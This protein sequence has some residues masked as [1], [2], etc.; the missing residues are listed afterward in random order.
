MSKSN[1]SVNILPDICEYAISKK[2]LYDPKSLKYKEVRFECIW[3]GGTTPKPKYKLSLNR[4]KGTFKCWICKQ[5]GGTIDFIMA[6]ENKSKD[7]VIQELREKAGLGKGKPK[8]RHPAEKLTVTQLKL[9]GFKP[10]RSTMNM[11]PAYKKRVLDWIWSEWNDFLDYKRKCALQTLMICIK[12]DI[13]YKAVPQIKE[14]SKE[15]GYDLLPD[16]FEAYGSGEQAPKWAEGVKEWVDALYEAFYKQDQQI[17]GNRLENDA[18][19]L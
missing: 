16:V 8:K 10:I 17:S 14:M 1:Y 3:C 18:I 12:A 2:L 9:I 7:E 11:S 13:F 4:E 19:A 6:L 15:I 5:E